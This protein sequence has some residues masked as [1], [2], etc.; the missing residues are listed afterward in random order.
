MPLEGRVLVADDDAELL[1]VVADTLIRLG[2]DVIRASTGAELI[3]RLAE[4]GPFDLII[5]DVAMPWM[6]GLQ[7]CFETLHVRKRSY[8]TWGLPKY[9]RSDMSGAT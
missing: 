2:A 4:Y 3:E 9:E 1:E 7:A 8:G 6:T 5:T